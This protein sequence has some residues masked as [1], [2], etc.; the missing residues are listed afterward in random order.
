VSGTTVR[1]LKVGTVRI[2][3]T[4]AATG[5]YNAASSYVTVK[6]L[7]AATTKLTAANQAKGIKLTWA[8]VAGA[9]GYVIY[10]NN[11]AVKTI[12][13]GATVTFTDTKA[14]TN[15]AKYTYKVVARAANGTST[16]SKSLVTY[17]VAKPAIKSLK[18]SASKK[19]TSKWAKNAKGSGYE[20]QY[21]LKKNFAGAKKVT[22]TKNSVVTK[23]F[24]KLKKGKVYYV[25]MRTYKKV[26]KTKYYS[27][28]SAVKKVKIAK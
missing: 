25:R 19:M 9:T 1:G 20:I 26:G 16:L 5:N 28:W 8:K 24:K 10:R 18:N 4:T 23:T 2:N 14:N 15:G 6:V 7:P 17:R 12:T 22:A 27:A 21:G 13:N 11:A 3:V